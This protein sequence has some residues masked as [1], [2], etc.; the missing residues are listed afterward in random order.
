MPAFKPA[1]LR[2]MA[3]YESSGIWAV[4][5]VGPFRH[6]MVRHGELDLPPELAV[7]FRAWIDDYLDRLE[8]PRI[9]DSD[10]FNAEG[11]RLASALKRHVGPTVRV[12]FVP[13]REDG[14]LAEEVE[15]P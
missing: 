5:A 2:V 13:E 4:G 10:A 7:A 11:S 9:W 1:H 12:T 8:S 15:V 6:G 14:G 3:E